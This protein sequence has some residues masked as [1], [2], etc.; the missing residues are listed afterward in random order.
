MIGFGPDCKDEKLHLA[1]LGGGIFS[2]GRTGDILAHE[3]E[4][5]AT[6]LSTPSF[7]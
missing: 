6:T 3:F 1:E 5:V 4:R 2:K 7:V